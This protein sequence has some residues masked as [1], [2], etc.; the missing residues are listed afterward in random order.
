MSKRPSQKM[1]YILLCSLAVFGVV[2]VRHLLRSTEGFE[3]TFLAQGLL[4]FKTIIEIGAS[5]YG[6]T[7]L[8]SAIAYLAMKEPAPKPARLR[9]YP[10]VGIMYLCCND[11]DHSAVESLAGIK[12]RGKLH[13][14][15]HDDSS[16][17]EARSEVDAVVEALRRRTH[18]KILLLRRP[19]RDGGKPGAVNYVLEQTGHLYDYFLLCDNDSTLLE[20][21]NIDE[22]L[23]YFEDQKVAIV[24]CR[25]IAVDSPNYCVV[26]RLLSL[27][28][29]AFHLFVVVCSK[30]GWRRFNGHNAFLST[31]MV[32]EAGGFTPGYFSDDL[33]LAI[34]LNLK[35]YSV[36]YAPEIRLGEKHPP[37]YSAFRRRTYKWA[38]GSVQI[39]RTRAW[40]VLTSPCLSLAEK[41]SFFQ[42]TG[43]YVCQA[44]LLFYLAVTFLVEP[45]FLE[46]HQFNPTARLI[47]GSVIIFVVYPPLLSYFA[48]EGKLKGCLGSLIMCGLVYGTPSFPSVRGVYDCL[49]KRPREWTPT[50][51]L[52]HG[53]PDL[54][55]W[56]ETLFG[57]FLLGVPL[58]TFPALLYLPNSYFLAGRF[59]SAIPLSRLYRDRPTAV[60]H[61]RVG[62]AKAGLY[63]LGIRRVPSP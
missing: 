31:R 44:I 4:V 62:L 60:G 46:G 6:F 32:L 36:V 52:S 17:P 40:A 7:F 18:S 48:K 58:I 20:P 37:S 25:S 38:Y 35:G 54:S 34:R 61:A 22:V 63:D 8:Y 13:L 50:N 30:L 53:R 49:W 3:L 43:L 15:V 5:F 9:E 33:D 10:P 59:L 24:Q 51:A 19:R 45:F 41:L 42:Y 23:R 16:L 29:D 39:L 55:L 11:L 57:V 28:I 2:Y 12:Y 27:S 47:A 14:I 26:N 56:G 21:V 1:A